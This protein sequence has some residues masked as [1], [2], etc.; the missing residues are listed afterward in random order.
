M[1][2]C[3][4]RYQRQVSDRKGKIFYTSIT[5]L[6]H[7]SKI[8]GMPSS[9]LFLCRTFRSRSVLHGQ[10]TGSSGKHRI[11]CGIAEQKDVQPLR[12]SVPHWL[13]APGSEVLLSGRFSTL[14]TLLRIFMLMMR[15]IGERVLCGK[16]WNSVSLCC[17]RFEG[18][19]AVD[20]APPQKSSDIRLRIFYLQFVQ[21]PHKETP[22][23]SGTIRVQS[24]R[25]APRELLP[26]PANAG[27]NDR[28]KRGPFKT[29]SPTY[30]R[31]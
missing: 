30:A 15:E 31:Q 22:F 25:T 11:W 19:T 24:G 17:K 23:L 14:P 7:I 9:I 26:K 29:L 3:P 10:R 16:R 6:S 1:T 20:N 12:W 5:S 4:I 27:K 18:S 2:A 21:N 28:R 13:L 8:S